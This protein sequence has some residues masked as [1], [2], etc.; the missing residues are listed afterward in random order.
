[1]CN[2]YIA[3]DAIHEAKQALLDGVSTALTCHDFRMIRFFCQLAL[4]HDILDE[5][6]RQ[7]IVRD[8]DNFLQAK[9]I[10]ESRLND[11]ITHVG[12]V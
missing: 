7:R 5:F 6:T 1:M 4:H 10:P 11:Y 8:V 12:S 3:T 2:L 9:D